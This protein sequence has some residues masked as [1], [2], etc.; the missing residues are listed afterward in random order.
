MFMCFFGA[1]WLLF[2]RTVIRRVTSTPDPNS[3]GRYRD[4]PQ[5]VH[6]WGC[7]RR[8]FCG[9]SAEK[10]RNFEKIRLI[11]SGKSVESSRKFFWNF[12]RHFC[13]NPFP[14]DPKV[15]CWTPPFSITILVQKYALLLAESSIPPPSKEILMPKKPEELFSG[16]LRQFRVIDYAKEFSEN[17]LLGNYVNFA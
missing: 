7:Q 9:N 12:Q 10:S 4:T 2:V 11:A 6:L 14:N 16:W 8:V 17:Y 5:A 3:F 1:W 15:N 13:N